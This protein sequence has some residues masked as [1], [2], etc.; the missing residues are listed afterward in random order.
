MRGSIQN[1]IENLTGALTE[2]GFKFV[3]AFQEKGIGLIEKLTDAVSN[4]DPQP[5]IDAAVTIGNVIA[6]IIGIVWNLRFFILGAAAAWGIY[7]TAMLGAAIVAPI[8]DMIKAVQTLMKAQ[9]GMNVAQAVFNYLLTTNPIGLA[10][11][12]IGILVGL[13]MACEG[14]MQRLM[15]VLQLLG[16]VLAAVFLPALAA[17]SP[18]WLQ[19]FSL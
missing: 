11:V 3:E 13:I 14:K 19:L 12:A 10:V 6:D 17:I 9:K 2:L 5:I 15:G 1:K 4:F 7:K 18:F 16:M 8:L